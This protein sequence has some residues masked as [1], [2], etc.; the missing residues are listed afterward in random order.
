[1]TTGE[2]QW[3]L[4]LLLSRVIKP[5]GCSPTRRKKGWGSMPQSGLVGLGEN[6]NM[7]VQERKPNFQKRRFIT[8]E[9][10]ELY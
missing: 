3:M 1:M 9:K 7:R 5:E 6:G 10:Y 2:K 4:E 8:F